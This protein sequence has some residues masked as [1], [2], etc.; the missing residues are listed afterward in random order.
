VS[1][2]QRVREAKQA[3]YRE[4]VLEAA[5]RVFAARGY[6]DAKIEQIARESQL[7]LGTLYT[8]FA[9]KSEIFQAVHEQHDAELLRCGLEPARGVA[10]PLEALVAGVRGYTRYFVEHPAFLRMTLRE[11]ATWG[12]EQA[13]ARSRM[14]TQAWKRGVAMLGLAIERCSEAGLVHESDPTLLARMLIAMQQV[15][16][17]HWLESEMTEPPAAVVERAGEDVRRFLGRRADLQP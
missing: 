1:G 7:S 16:L 4:L 5:E 3:A 9:G 12:T 11:G 13:V 15:R 17:A 6:E 2:K 14:R 8:V 10:D